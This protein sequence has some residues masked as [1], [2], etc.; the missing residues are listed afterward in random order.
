MQL[1][2]SNIPQLANLLSGNRRREERNDE[3][4]PGCANGLLRYAP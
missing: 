4:N 3:E 1:K 2:L